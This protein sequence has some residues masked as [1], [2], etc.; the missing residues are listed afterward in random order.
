MKTKEELEAEIMAM[1]QEI[2]ALFKDGSHKSRTIVIK[3]K[4][5]YTDN[6][7]FVDFVTKKI[8]ARGSGK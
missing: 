7:V 5:T 8:Y 1:D 3:P 2:K 4:P 6:V